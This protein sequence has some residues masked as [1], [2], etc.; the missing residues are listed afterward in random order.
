MQA[1]LLHHLKIALLVY[2]WSILGVQSFSHRLY[3]RIN[4]FASY[5]RS[6]ICICC[7]VSIRLLGRN[8]FLKFFEYNVRVVY[9]FGDKL[10]QTF[11]IVQTLPD[12]TIAKMS[13]DPSAKRPP[14]A[15]QLEGIVLVCLNLMCSL[16]L[17]VTCS[18]LNLSFQTVTEG[19]CSEE[20]LADGRTL[21]LE[22]IRSLTPS[23][24]GFIMSLLIN[25]AERLGARL[26]PYIERLETELTKLSNEGNSSS[27]LEQ[28]PSGSKVAVNRLGF[29]SESAFQR[30]KKRFRIIFT[31]FKFPHEF[32]TKQS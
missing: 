4:C 10:G 1:W 24:K 2:L 29:F 32:H 6:V 14:L 26:L 25:A 3:C 12:D 5:A 21:L 13:I 20:G 15:L 22:L 7:G 27:F 28:Q 19:D 17:H 23:T 18:N 8:R 9:D 16:C 30:K 11:Q 31:N